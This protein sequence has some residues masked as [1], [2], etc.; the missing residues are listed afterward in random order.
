[1]AFTLHYWETEFFL[2]V[3]V[4]LRFIILGYLTL[5]TCTIILLGML[6][7]KETRIS[8]GH[9]SLWLMSDFT[10]YFGC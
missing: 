5:Y 9:L 8:F 2:L 1:M 3:V 7:A 6:H 10:F 4:F